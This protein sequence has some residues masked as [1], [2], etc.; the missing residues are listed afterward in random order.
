MCTT[1][2][3]HDPRKLEE[4]LN[5]IVGVGLQWA[6]CPPGGHFAASERRTWRADLEARLNGP[7]QKTTGTAFRLACPV[8]VERYPAHK[9]GEQI[10]FTDNNTSAGRRLRL[11]LQPGVMYTRQA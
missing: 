2:R 7:P 8:Q 9:S 6:F 4:Q 3:S 5:A 10:G 11:S 1:C